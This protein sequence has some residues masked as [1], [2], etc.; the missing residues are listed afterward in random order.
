MSPLMRTSTRTR[1]RAGALLVALA[2]LL[3][4]EPARAQDAARPHAAP[5]SET[6]AVEMTGFHSDR[7]VALVALFTSA[8]GFPDDSSKAYLR[9]SAAIR[10]GKARVLL[11]RLPPGTYAIA[12]L[13]DEDGDKKMRTS[14]LGLPKEGYGASRDARGRFG[15]PRFED[16]RLALRPGRAMTARIKI[17]YH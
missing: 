13:H 14:A 6:I 2:A 12:V 15:P 17:V 4:T 10:N 9:R 11:R 5:G 8:K 16:A 1:S 7:G 3:F